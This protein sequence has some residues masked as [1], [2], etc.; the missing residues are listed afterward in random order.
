MAYEFQIVKCKHGCSETFWT[1]N[2][3]ATHHLDVHERPLPWPDKQPRPILP[4]ADGTP[5]TAWEIARAG[6]ALTVNGIPR[7]EAR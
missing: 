5:P 1:L 6:Q 4:P 7:K 3:L 2:E